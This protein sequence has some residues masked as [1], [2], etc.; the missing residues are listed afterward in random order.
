MDKRDVASFTLWGEGLMGLLRATR[1]LPSEYRYRALA[2]VLSGFEDAS[3][4]IL[5][6]GLTVGSWDR[7]DGEPEFGPGEAEN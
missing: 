3:V 7:G 2:S 1:D 6:G 4:A 5:V